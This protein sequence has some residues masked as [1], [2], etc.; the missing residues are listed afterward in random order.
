MDH[1]TADVERR[2]DDTLGAEPLQA[3]HD[4]NDV[5]DRI[6]SANLVEM[7]AIDWHLVYRSLGLGQSQE[8]ELCLVAASLRKRGLV[9]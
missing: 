7:D 2:A 6:Q 8:K 5:D 4:A 1:A 3:E 9:D